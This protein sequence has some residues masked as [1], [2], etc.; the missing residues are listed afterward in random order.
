MSPSRTVSRL[1][2]IALLLAPAT[3]RAQQGA[4]D[5]MAGLRAQWSGVAS[6]VLAAAKELT[7]AE[8]AYRPVKGVRSFGEL[9]GHVAGTQNMI[10]AAVLGDKVPAEDAVEKGAKTKAALV[11]ALEASNAYCAKA[12]AIAGAKL[13]EKVDMFGEKDT[14]VGALALNAVHTGEH[15]GNIVTYMRMQ[16][17]VPPSSKK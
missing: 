14:K 11:A 17:K 5:A 15:Y 13:S 9:V 12:Y 10:C 1:F 2:V 16:G 8:Y 7:E 6:N 4:V 3:L